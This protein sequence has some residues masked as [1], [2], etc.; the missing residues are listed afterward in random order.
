MGVNPGCY[1][2]VSKVAV[3][4]A[5][6]YSL[7]RCILFHSKVADQF[8]SDVW[9]CFSTCGKLSESEILTRM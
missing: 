7:R 2:G 8:F 9:S 4:G 3:P 1:R 5:L 6:E